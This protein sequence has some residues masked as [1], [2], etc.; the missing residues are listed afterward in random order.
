M[1]VATVCIVETD[2]GHEG[3]DDAEEANL[4]SPSLLLFRCSDAESS[5]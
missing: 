1:S 3:K 4:L 2:A 5:E